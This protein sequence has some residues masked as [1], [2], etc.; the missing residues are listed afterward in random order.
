M[1][2]QQ[3][4]LVAMKMLYGCVAPFMAFCD[5]FVAGALALSLYRRR[6]PG[7]RTL[8]MII[9]Y[10]ICTGLSTAT[11]STTF[12]LSVIF[13]SSRIPSIVGPCIGPVSIIGFLANLH[14]R[15]LLYNEHSRADI[16]LLI[17][18]T[19]EVGRHSIHEGQSE[20]ALW[21]R[22]SRFDHQAL[23]SRAFQ[24]NPAVESPLYY[25]G[26]NP[27]RYIPEIEEIMLRDQRPSHQ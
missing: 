12:A 24:D 1:Y 22:V 21:S 17:S 5:F 15:S 10:V 8:N 25:P 6:R 9:I 4:Q 18:I 27:F 23:R 26:A 16:D 19:R 14:S 3:D 7:L 20:R 2:S 11:M 13:L